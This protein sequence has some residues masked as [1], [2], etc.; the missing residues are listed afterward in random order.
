MEEDILF[1]EIFDKLV[2]ERGETKGEFLIDLGHL[3]QKAM[4]FFLEELRKFFP[5]MEINCYLTKNKKK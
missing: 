5:E 1:F 4:P 2:T 3:S